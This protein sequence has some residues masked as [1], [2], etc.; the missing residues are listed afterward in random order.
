MFAAAFVLKLFPFIVTVVPTGPESGEKELI[1]GGL[2]YVNVPSVELPPGE[3]TITSP[4]DPAPTIAVILEV[5]AIVKL[6]TATPPI[7]I[8][9]TSDKLEPLIVIIVP[10]VPVNG[11]KE[12]IFGT[13]VQPFKLAAPP[14]VVTFIAP[15]PLEGAVAV[16]VVGDTTINAAGIPAKLTVVVL[17]KLVPVIV[18]DVPAIPLP[19]VN[20]VIAGG[21]K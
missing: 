8:E 14:G 15:E 11:V 17:S 20:E 19:G 18:T 21:G 4:L 16:M 2:K 10:L 12:V 7:V 13:A 9:L 1:T 6:L 5:P 3:D